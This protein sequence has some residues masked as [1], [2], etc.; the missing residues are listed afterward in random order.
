[1]DG[2]GAGAACKEVAGTVESV[3]VG[4]L[5]LP[6]VLPTPRNGGSGFS[7][8]YRKTRRTKKKKIYE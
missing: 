7:G 8:S 1:M 5:L 6:K 4:L 3:P 2:D